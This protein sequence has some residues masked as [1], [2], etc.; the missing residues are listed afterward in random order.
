MC[1]GVRAAPPDG[2]RPSEVLPDAPE[3]CALVL[4][5]RD[6]FVAEFANQVA[7]VGSG[8]A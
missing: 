2:N 4:V 3:Q 5:A 6:D 7:T 8:Q 1:G